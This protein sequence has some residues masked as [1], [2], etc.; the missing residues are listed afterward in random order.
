[1]L[2]A[3]QYN[4]KADTKFYEFYYEFEI[5]ETTDQTIYSMSDSVTKALENIN[6][7]KLFD[8]RYYRDYISATDTVVETKTSTS[9][10]SIILAFGPVNNHKLGTLLR[11]YDVESGAL[12][13]EKYVG[14][15][16]ADNIVNRDLYD[17]VSANYFSFKQP[18]IVDAR[19]MARLSNIY[20][21]DFSFSGL[22]NLFEIL[23]LK[24]E[25]YSMVFLD[26]L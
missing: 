19:I 2:E 13:E 12:I 15:T 3:A 25:R 18:Y 1:M 11:L 5:K 26:S 9:G 6:P 22:R 24:W 16:L 4:I 17:I 23:A 8:A 10:S 14:S 21:P 20:S 7:R